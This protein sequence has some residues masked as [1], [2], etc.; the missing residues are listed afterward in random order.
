[1]LRLIPAPLHRILFRLADFARRRVY[2]VTRPTLRGVSIIGHDNQHRVLLIRLSYG[3]NTWQFP[4]GGIKRH[5]EP[6]AAA[7]R[8]M[9]EETGCELDGLIPIGELE[10]DVLGTSGRTYLFAGTIL[11]A[12]VADQREVRDA[13][14]FPTHSLPE[15]LSKRTRVRLALWQQSKQG[16]PG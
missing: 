14:L 6:E 2:A 8:E 13:R 15:P 7:R 12:P 10:E 9:R 5:E 16:D 1:M 4:G 3:A 11:N